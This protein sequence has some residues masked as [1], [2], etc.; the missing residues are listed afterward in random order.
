MKVVFKEIVADGALRETK[1]D[2]LQAEFQK[3]GSPHL[4]AYITWWLKAS[5]A[6]KENKHIDFADLFC[7]KS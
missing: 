4:H 2:A 7:Q 6:E 1:Y 5:I 3:S